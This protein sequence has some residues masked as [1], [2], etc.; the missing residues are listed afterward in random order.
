MDNNFLSFDVGNVI[1]E[2]K[3]LYVFE[4]DEAKLY[5]VAALPNTLYSEIHYF[6]CF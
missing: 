6:Y 3:D 4:N 2:N 1:S 5:S